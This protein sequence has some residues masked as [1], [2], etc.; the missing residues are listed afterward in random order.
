M[1]KRVSQ[2]L[3]VGCFLLAI[4]TP[5]TIMLLSERSEISLH[6]KRRLAE[7]PQWNWD[8][9]LL[10][11][12]PQKFT[13]FFED[14]YGLRETLVERSQHIKKKY[15][16]KSPTWMVIRGEEDWLFVDRRDSLRDHIGLETQSMETL[17]EWQR[18]LVEKREYLRSR[19]IE[20]YFVPIPNKMSLYGHF[21]PPRIR[22]RSGRT[23][24]DQF[25]AHLERQDQ[26]HH[27]TDL[28]PILADYRDSHP[29]DPLY[30]RT[31]S[32][33]N[34]LGAFV[35][36]R[37]IMQQLGRV[38]PQL[39]PPLTFEDMQPQPL[40]MDGDLANII[41]MDQQAGEPGYD[42]VPL[43]R[44]ARKGNLPLAVPGQAQ[45][46]EQ[47][48]K[49]LPESNGCDQ[50][51]LRAVIVHDSFGAYLKPFFSESFRRVVFVNNRG[52]SQLKAILESEQPDLFLELLIERNL[53]TRMVSPAD[54][55]DR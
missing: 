3:L 32:H 20:Y 45:P 6:E 48:K 5:M 51:A 41:D 12:F 11:D 27:Y 22:E 13:A 7:P 21:L 16:D 35:A 25:L 31:D 34:S 15:L 26:F 24:L 37:H 17:D 1:L 50:K 36:Y 29:G 9:R 47:K 44:C 54:L 38:L 53:R 55:A 43:Q 19:D 14:H 40:T 2:Y 18:Q 49:T 10:R 23:V 33:W 28:E 42:L 39:E 4:F 46:P 30:F 52:Q 8:T